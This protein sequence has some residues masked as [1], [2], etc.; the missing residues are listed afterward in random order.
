MPTLIKKGKGEIHFLQIGVPPLVN[1]LI[2]KCIVY[3][4]EHRLNAKEVRVLAQNIFD[5]YC[6]SLMTE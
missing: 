6:G 2:R 3:E 5:L 1:D 4:E